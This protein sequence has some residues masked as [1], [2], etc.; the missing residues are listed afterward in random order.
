MSDTAPRIARLVA[1]ANGSSQPW[2]TLLDDGTSWLVK[3]V[4]AGP[5]PDAL[6]AEY[7]ANGLGRMWGHPVVCS[8]V[9]SWFRAQRCPCSSRFGSP[10]SWPGSPQPGWSTSGATTASS[11]IGW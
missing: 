7:L 3:F 4:G 8:I 11:R 5:G 10:T 9:A 1:A 2:F 6:A